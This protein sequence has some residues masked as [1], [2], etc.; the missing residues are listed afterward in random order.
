MSL[1]SELK[2]RNVFRVAAGYAVLSWLVL[3]ITDVLVNALEL[4]PGLSKTVVAVL[5][6]GFIPALVLSWVYEMTPEGIKKESEISREDSVTAHTA[7]KLDRA[8]IGLLVL[9]IGLFAMDR[10]GGEGDRGAAPTS[11][12]AVADRSVG[13]ALPRTDSELES[14]EASVAVLPF[15]TR[16]RDEDDTFFSEGV[17][18]DL[19]T[20]LAKIGD[21]KVISRTSVM[22]YRDT[23]KNLRQ[24]GQE[25]GVSTIVEGAVQRSGA[26]VRITAQLID[27]TTD[28]HLWAETYDRELTA[29][30]LFAIQTEIAT[31]IASALSAT[32][33]PEEEEALGRQLT[34]DL[35]ALEAYQRARRSLASF[36]LDVIQNSLAELGFAIERDPGFAAAYALRARYHTWNYWALETDPIYLQRAWADIEAARA[37]DPNLP[38]ADIAEGIYHYW[39]FLDYP[40]ALEVLEPALLAYPNDADLLSVVSWVNRRYGRFDTAMELMRRAISVDPRNIDA[41]NSLAET[42][43]QMGEYDEVPG[44]IEAMDGISPDAPRTIALRAGLAEQRDGDP[45]SAARYWSLVSNDLTWALIS[46]YSA[47]MAA[48]QFDQAVVLADRNGTVLNRGLTATALMLRGLALHTAGDPSAR[49]TLE[50]ARTELEAMLAERPGTGEHAQAL[51][52]VVGALGDAAAA[53]EICAR[54]LR[55]VGRDAFDHYRY[56]VVYAARG[57]AMAGEHDRAFDLL[58]GAITERVGPRRNTLRLDP[59][60]NDLHDDPRWDALIEAAPL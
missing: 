50:A 6:I 22:E 52:Q 18:D 15:T 44:I 2:R 54:G 59:L 7:A 53:V 47:R 9:A 16:S 30:N 23:T 55:D 39:G 58:Q 38:E 10:F 12:A 20:Q 25:L 29:S 21:I 3:Q 32:L 56:Y 24:I 57:L 40:R 26:T 11:D 37:I 19:L 45:E 5:L 51:C 36:R 46:E 60:L 42:L 33:S 49:A 41:L 28:E 35:Q 14:I 13:A 8:V 17:H 1:F 34:D 27:A 31:S 48:G 43:L 4:A